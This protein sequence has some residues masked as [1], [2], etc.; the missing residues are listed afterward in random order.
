MSNHWPACQN[1]D[2]DPS[3]FHSNILQEVAAASDQEVA[4]VDIEET[5]D[6]TESDEEPTSE[7]DRG[8][9]DSTQPDAE[10]LDLYRRMEM[11]EEAARLAADETPDNAL[12][13]MRRE[14]QRR[15][16]RDEAPQTSV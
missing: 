12:A 6:E 8:I 4:S 7:D 16:A 13:P 14:M 9:D 10:R 1:E 5:S 2:P 15:R 11:E 3:M